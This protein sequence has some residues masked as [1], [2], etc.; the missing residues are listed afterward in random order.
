MY[1]G[2]DV[3]GT[4]TFVAS[5]SDEGVIVEQ[6]RFLTPKVYEDFIKELED[7]IAQLSN[8]E[9]KAATIALPGLIDRDSGVAIKFGNLPWTNV[10]IVN[11][12]S[13]LLKCPVFIENDAKLAGLSESMLVKDEFSRVLYVTVS[14]GIGIGFTNHQII[15]K[16]AGDGGGKTILLDRNGKH[17]PWE[18]I[19]SGKSIVEI[20]GK[21]AKDI[22]DE[23]TWK[24]IVKDL[25][26]G[27]IQLIGIF[28]PQLIVVGGSVG[29]YFPKYGKLLEEQ[30]TT[31]NMPEFAMPVLREAGR[32]DEA[33]VY[34]CYDYAK[35]ELS[36]V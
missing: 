25:A 20:Y 24:K 2:V 18:S 32:P 27:M 21:M 36:R 16:N 30:L 35:S 31:Y 22:E 26:D 33:V 29:N 28:E 15:D 13:A 14:T 34:G 23:K 17:V 5:L 3:G 7:N 12:V 9:F 6:F 1:L 11:D 19:A 8:T 10:N 4:K